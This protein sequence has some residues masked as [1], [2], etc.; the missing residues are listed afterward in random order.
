M[1]TQTDRTWYFV[2]HGE[3]DWNAE[4]RMQ[5]Q[6]ESNLNENGRQH[7]DTNGR[8]LANLGI[9][10]VWASPQVRV[11]QTA[12]II[13]T[14]MPLAASPVFDDRL[15]EWSAGD[16]SGMLYADIARDRP[17]EWAAWVADRYG[18]RPPG[19]ENFLDLEH[20]ADS[21]LADVADHPARTVAVFAHG[22]IIRI[23]VSRLVPMTPETVLNVKQGN[24]VVIRVTQS[25]RDAMIDHFVGGQGPRPGLPF[26]E[27]G[28]A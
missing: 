15:M 8:W 2:R 14:H 16:W 7:A 6:W 28:A 26:G 11:R 9:Q 22:F 18:Y 5:G 10:Q 25:A 13:A 17:E 4:K 24:D 20:R 12:D 3:T 1:Q 21:F 19:G 23:L 27:Q